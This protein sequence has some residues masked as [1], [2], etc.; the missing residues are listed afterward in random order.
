MS[1]LPPR[2]AQYEEMKWNGLIKSWSRDDFDQEFTFKPAP[3]RD[4]P[5]F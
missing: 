4:V 2:M 5:D 1:K 3:A